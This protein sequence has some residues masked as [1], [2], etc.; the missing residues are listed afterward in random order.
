MPFLTVTWAGLVGYLV[1]YP[2]YAGDAPGQFGWL[3]EEVEPF[4][5]S[6][7]HD[8]VDVLAAGRTV[9]APRRATSSYAA[10][11]SSA[12]PWPS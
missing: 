6:Q 9:S 12:I 11:T 3:T 7:G 2:G 4:L 10:I 8:P 5:R 1:A